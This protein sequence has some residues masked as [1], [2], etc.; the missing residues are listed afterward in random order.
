[1]KPYINSAIIAIAIIAGFFILGAAYKYKFKATE[2]ITVTGLA[3]KI[4]P[5]TKSYGQVITAGR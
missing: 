4:L 2:N 5:V 3:E 1:M